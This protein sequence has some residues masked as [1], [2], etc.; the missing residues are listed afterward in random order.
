MKYTVEYDEETRFFEVVRWTE[1]DGRVCYKTEIEADAKTIFD[2]LV[3]EASIN[4][5][6]DE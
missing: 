6:V 2:A 1:N 5:P 3:L 4:Y